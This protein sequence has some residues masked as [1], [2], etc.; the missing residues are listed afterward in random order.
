M[1]EK[2]RKGGGGGNGSRWHSRWWRGG[3]GK[4]ECGGSPMCARWRRGLGI[5]EAVN[6]KRR[7]GFLIG[8]GGPTEALQGAVA[9]A[10]SSRSVVEHD[11]PGRWASVW[12]NECGGGVGRRAAHQQAEFS[13]C[14]RG[15]MTW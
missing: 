11:Q 5:R 15:A 2:E 14:S 13:R 7:G 8:R 1:A 4:E 10:L 12:D 6:E 3:K 9:V